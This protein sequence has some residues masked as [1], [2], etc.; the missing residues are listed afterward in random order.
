[1]F[2]ISIGLII[3]CSICALWVVIVRLRLQRASKKM[4]AN[5]L[6]NIV[7]EQLNYL[8]GIG[9][10][11]NINKKDIIRYNLCR[12]IESKLLA[13]PCDAYTVLCGMLCAV[14]GKTCVSQCYIRQQKKDN[15]D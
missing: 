3:G 9:L 2:D 7:E 11:L 15:S 10:D 6:Q 14:T 5:D 1:M 4:Y 13:K 8:I 12:I